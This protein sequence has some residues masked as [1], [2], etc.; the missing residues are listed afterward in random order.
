VTTL[1][2]SSQVWTV[3]GVV[4]N[5]VGVI[6]LFR[7][8]MQYRERRSGHEFLIIGV[9]PDRQ[10]SERLYDALGWVGLALIIA[11]AAFQLVGAVLTPA[12]AWVMNTT[13]EFWTA[14]GT[15]GLL[16]IAVGA[17]VVAIFQL[18]AAKIER[19][20]NLIKATRL[21]EQLRL[22]DKV[23]LQMVKPKV[24]AALN[25]IQGDGDNGDAALAA[26]MF[27][28]VDLTKP[29]KDRPEPG[30]SY[31]EAVGVYINLLERNASY[32][33]E[34][35]IDEDLYFSQYDYLVAYLYFL[36]SPHLWEPGQRVPNPTLTQFATRA[37]L[38]AVQDQDK[39]AIG[40]D[41]F[42]FYS[43]RARKYFPGEQI[44][45]IL[46]AAPRRNP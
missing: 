24:A 11:G 5:A 38:H 21:S 39:P 32:A 46:A 10:K 23:I 1:S 22:T 4:L 9:S 33:K 28:T 40:N 20:D 12:V 7:F 14:F 34:R 3:I 31:I 8:G 43:E 27:A 29:V 41:M 17:F 19:N 15:C 30:K 6:L 45:A 36:F 25:T 16:A 42:D 35:L 13:P 18:Q 26:R 2:T 44:E 37:F